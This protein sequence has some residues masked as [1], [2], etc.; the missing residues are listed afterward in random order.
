V[1]LFP[2]DSSEYPDWVQMH[3]SL[4]DGGSKIVGFITSTEL[5]IRLLANI[6]GCCTPHFLLRALGEDDGGDCG[7]GDS[8]VLKTLVFLLDLHELI[9]V[10]LNDPVNRK[11]IT[12]IISN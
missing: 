7:R 9:D 12:L 1:T 8:D 6:D 2:A 10:E 3:W 11:P 4:I 5:D